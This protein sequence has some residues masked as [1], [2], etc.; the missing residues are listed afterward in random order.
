MP[1]HRRPF[2]R[3]T[4]SVNSLL[5][6]RM[7]ISYS[8][9]VFMASGDAD[10]ELLDS[11]SLY[12]IEDYGIRLPYCKPSRTSLKRLK[13]TVHIK[14]VSMS[15][16]AVEFDLIGADCAL[17]N[18]LRRLLLAE[19]PSVAAEKVLLYQNTSLIQDEICAVAS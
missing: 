16:E 18:T 2:L 1:P 10:S 12:I 13:K 14:V 9:P 3:S 5:L 17:A 19:V 15:A 7:H 8:Q 11:N 6:F 4:L